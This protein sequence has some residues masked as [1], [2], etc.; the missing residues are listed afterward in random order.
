MSGQAE[1]GSNNERWLLTYADLITLLM[2]FFVILYAISEA[3]K[4]K[5]E[6]LRTSIQRALGTEAMETHG[7]RILSSGGAGLLENPQRQVAIIEGEGSWTEPSPVSQNAF[8]ATTATQSSLDEL[9]QQLRQAILPLAAAQG[10]ADNVS[11]YRTKEGVIISLS[12]NLLFDSGKA[13]LKPAG[14]A[15]LHVVAQVL[16]PLPNRLRVEGHTDNVA[17]STPLYPSNWELS[18][19]RSIVTARYLT[20]QERLDH[21]RVGAAAYGEFRPVADNGKRE[22]RSRNRRV[23]IL[24]LDVGVAQEDWKP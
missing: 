13:E 20:E 11:V 8:P 4:E 5:F 16:R 14:V 6:Q 3:D 23:D 21:G 19:A 9:L 24:V 1:R 2:A 18:S 10:V 12:G 7:Q 17:I 22:G 15:F